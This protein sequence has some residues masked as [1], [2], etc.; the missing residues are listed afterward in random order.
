M[1]HEYAHAVG[2]YFDNNAVSKQSF[3]KYKNLR[4]CLNDMQYT[5]KSNK[6]EERS[7]FEEDGP[8][9][10]EKYKISQYTEEDW[11]DFISSKVIKKDGPNF[12]CFLEN[13]TGII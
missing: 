8:V 10:F 7:Y 5:L 1:A 9:S 13:Q 6:E 11:A 2:N 4:M 3:G 12:G